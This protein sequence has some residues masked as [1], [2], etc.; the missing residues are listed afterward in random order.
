M[1]FIK[2]LG[3]YGLHLLAGFTL[4]LSTAVVSADQTKTFPLGNAGQIVTN[5]NA[6]VEVN[7]NN[8]EYT[9]N[10]DRGGLCFS[11]NQTTP[12]TITAGGNAVDMGKFGVDDTGKITGLISADNTGVYAGSTA[13]CD[14]VTSVI[15]EGDGL[16]GLNKDGTITVIAAIIFIIAV[17]SSDNDG[18]IPPTPLVIP[19]TTPPTNPITTPRTGGGGGG[20]GGGGAVSP[21]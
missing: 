15:N 7:E 6:N 17:A 12:L 16:F 14:G 8:G 10:L 1:T 5:S 19:T 20:G 13:T 2:Q 9:V 3:S 21:S 18:G 11:V 4:C